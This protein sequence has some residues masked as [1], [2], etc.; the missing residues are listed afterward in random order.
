[1]KDLNCDSILHNDDEYKFT[2][3]ILFEYLLIQEF[4]VAH[5]LLNLVLTVFGS[6]SITTVIKVNFLISLAIFSS[7]SWF[8]E[9]VLLID[10]TEIVFVNFTE[11]F[12]SLLLNLSLSTFLEVCSINV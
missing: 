1:M 12:N 2:F 10:Y 3:I 6:N 4:L 9:T 7:F 5:S 11:Y 8:P